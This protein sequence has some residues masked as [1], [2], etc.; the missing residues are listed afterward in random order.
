[1]VFSF[2]PGVFVER[3]TNLTRSSDSLVLERIH[4]T[5]VNSNAR[6][7]LNKLGWTIATF[8]QP[9]EKEMVKLSLKG[10]NEVCLHPY[11]RLMVLQLSSPSN[12][13]LWKEILIGMYGA[14][15]F[16]CLTNIDAAN[17]WIENNV[18]AEPDAFDPD[19]PQSFHY[20]L[21]EPET[22]P[23]VNEW[24]ESLGGR[25]DQE[26]KID[27]SG[28]ADLGWSDREPFFDGEVKQL[29]LVWGTRN[30][31]L[32]L[33]SQ[34]KEFAEATSSIAAAANYIKNHFRI[35]GILTPRGEAL[36]FG[37]PGCSNPHLRFFPN[38]QE[39][40]YKHGPDGEHV[41]S[42]FLFIKLRAA[43]ESLAMM[44][45]ELEKRLIS[46]TDITFEQPK[47]FC[48]RI[49]EEEGGR[50]WASV[51][52]PT[53]HP[54][55]HEYTFLSISDFLFIDLRKP[56][57]RL[58]L[59]THADKPETTFSDFCSQQGGV[60][61]SFLMTSPWPYGACAGIAKVI[62]TE[63]AILGFHLPLELKRAEFTL[64]YS[65]ASDKDK[66]YPNILFFNVA[67]VRDE[68]GELSFTKSSISAELFALEDYHSSDFP[69][70][71][72]V[73]KFLPLKG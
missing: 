41:V 40:E 62:T 69:N 39:Y 34:Q 46:Y 43:A 33:N 54:V 66:M 57:D 9:P 38:K 19:F 12:E 45:P 21:T 67:V 59:F 30:L 48:L 22:R 35:E 32:P 27:G 6:D 1:M 29:I 61:L 11:R 20:Y 14:G 53:Y 28:F 2:L 25:R 65:L 37:E 64:V 49:S 18:H 8:N 31:C 16:Q 36:L 71:V 47:E 50:L 5:T 26:L 15:W 13:S 42:D 60:P 7:V 44:F 72:L 10:G 52:W 56:D 24:L 70:G 17:K 4:M 68:N 58:K 63:Q 73:R 23:S 51:P 55:P 3:S